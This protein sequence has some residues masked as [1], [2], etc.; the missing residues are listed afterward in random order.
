MEKMQLHYLL[1]LNI[2]NK[3]DP[4]NDRFRIL[5][6]NGCT[7]CFAEINWEDYTFSIHK[8]NTIT[9]KFAELKT[10]AVDDKSSGL[11][12]AWEEEHRGFA[13][14]EIVSMSLQETADTEIL[15]VIG[16]SFPFFNREI[17]REIIRNMTQLKKVYFQAPDPDANILKERFLSVREDI[18]DN[19]LITRFDVGQFL[20]PNE[21]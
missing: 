20:L 15:I 9:K 2:L 14:D 3:K 19:N 12:F 17:D 7:D 6:L 18:P 8:L 1:A 5:K 4:T 16:Y 13:Y 10:K 11:S 21:L